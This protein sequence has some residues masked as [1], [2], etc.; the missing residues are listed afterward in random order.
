MPRFPRLTAPELFYHIFNRGT[1]K[2]PIFRQQ[3]DYLRFLHYL[4]FYKE[5]FDW[6]IYCYCLMPNHFHL[7]I[8]QHLDPLGQI[9]KSLQTAY[10]VFFN[11][12]YQ[13]I[14]PLVSGRYKSIIVQEGNYFLQVSK[15]IHLNPVKAG[16]CSKPLDYPYSSY[17][18]YMKGENPIIPKPIIDKRS[19]KRILGDVIS[20]Q[21]IRMYQSFVEEREDL[22]D[23]DIEKKSLDIFGNQRFSTKLNRLH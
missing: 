14:G 9:M 12:K 6:T 2:K 22:F 18:E 3:K 17:R 5:K 21:S 11:L 16:L 7:L 15:Y 10:G 23:Y 4:D 1:E 8:Q 13:R 20:P 19:M